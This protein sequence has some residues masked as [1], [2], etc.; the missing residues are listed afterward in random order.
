MPLLGPSNRIQP[1]ISRMDGI[2]MGA[3]V[4]RSANWR[5]RESV[6]ST[7]QARKPPIKSTRLAVAPAYST[8][9]ASADQM[10]NLP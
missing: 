7:S 4:N 2:R 1:L 8:E 6:R 10:R 5:T 3:K 9:L